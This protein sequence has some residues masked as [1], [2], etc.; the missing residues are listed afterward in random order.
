M[1]KNLYKLTTNKELID[2]KMM[3]TG[4]KKNGKTVTGYYNLPYTE[5]LVEGWKPLIID[6]PPEQVEDIEYERY[7]EETTTEIIQ[8]WRIKN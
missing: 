8:H 1:E 7:Y 2:I 5:L 6:I 3:Q 4:V